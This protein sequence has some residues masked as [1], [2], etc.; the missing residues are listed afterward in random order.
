MSAQYLLREGCRKRVG[1][2]VSISIWDDTWLP[3]FPYRI[4]TPDVGNEQ[5]SSVSDL[6]VHSTSSWNRELIEETFLPKDC[7]QIFSIPLS[8]QQKVA[9]TAFL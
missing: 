4:A 5:I 1:D 9:S 6:I 7:A 2:G 8:L 3:Q